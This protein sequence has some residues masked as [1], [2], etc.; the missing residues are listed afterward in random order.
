[1]S[2]TWSAR[3]RTALGA[4]DSAMK[5]RSTMQNQ[6]ALEA[7]PDGT[8]LATPVR[9]GAFLFTH[10]GTLQRAWNG[11]VLIHHNSKKHGR[12]VTTSFSEFTDGKN[13]AQIDFVP[14]SSAEGWLVAERARMD[15]ARGIRWTVSDNCEDMRARALTGRN[16]SPTRDS[17]VGV[18]LLGLAVFLASKL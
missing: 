2:R 17:F 18:G 6:I 4:S 15:V 10:Y 9:Y 14:Q 5:G 1:V 12:A 7:L 13:L 3:S 11:E 16:G 8:I